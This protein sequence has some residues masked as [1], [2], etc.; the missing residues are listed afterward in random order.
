MI[1]QLQKAR[2]A[3]TQEVSGITGALGIV[4]PRTVLESL[5]DQRAGIADRLRQIDEAIAALEDNP[6][7]E[8]VLTLIQRVY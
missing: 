5:K 4:Q 1:E 8:R 3:A 6:Q 2:Y 7:V